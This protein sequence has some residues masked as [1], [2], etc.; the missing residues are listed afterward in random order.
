MEEEEGINEIEDIKLTTEKY[1][2]FLVTDIKSF[3]PDIVPQALLLN[4]Y[5]KP[6]DKARKDWIDTIKFW[7]DIAYIN[8]KLL[9]YVIQ[10]LIKY[11]S[12]PTDDSDTNITEF[13]EPLYF[14]IL[15]DLD[16]GKNIEKKLTPAFKNNLKIDFVS[17]LISLKN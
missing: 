3:H 1:N 15:V 11:G 12:D 10:Y 4:E 2:T 13:L 14:D 7:P 17:Y 5:L 16:K 8:M 9:S 6:L